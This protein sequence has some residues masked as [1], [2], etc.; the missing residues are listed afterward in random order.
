MATAP[1]RRSFAAMNSLRAVRS[2]RRQVVIAGGG[3]GAVEAALAL[4]ALAGDLPGIELVAPEREFLYRALT[5]PLE[6]LDR[7]HAVRHRQDAISE[8]DAA[9]R[10][11]RLRSGDEIAYDALVVAVG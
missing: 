2:R 3:V 9:A 11:V 1:G 7:S 5:V 10:R 8:V 4:R 6:R